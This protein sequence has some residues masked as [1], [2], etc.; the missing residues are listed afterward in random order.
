M[1]LKREDKQR[2]ASVLWSRTRGLERDS[3][4]R[5]KQQALKDAEKRRKV[6]ETRRY[7]ALAIVVGGTALVVQSILRR[8]WFSVA[9]WGALVLLQAWSLTRD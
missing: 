2:T 7:L 5:L 8:D 3:L 9:V 4:K 6:R 1:P